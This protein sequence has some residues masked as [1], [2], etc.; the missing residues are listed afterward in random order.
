MIRLQG[1]GPELRERVPTFVRGTDL[2]SES[3]AGHG[4]LMNTATKIQYFENIETPSHSDFVRNH[5]HCVLC[6]TVLELKHVR[7]DSDSQIK[8]EAFCCECDL[9]TRAKIHTLN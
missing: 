3:V 6:G 7:N 5:G 1:P 4:G 8:E 9:K 2:A